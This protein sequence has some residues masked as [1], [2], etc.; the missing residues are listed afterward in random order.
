MQDRSAFSIHA[1]SRSFIASTS[2]HEGGRRSLAIEVGRGLIQIVID[3]SNVADIDL[4]SIITGRAEIEINHAGLIILAEHD[5]VRENVRAFPLAVAF[6]R[7]E[8]Q[9]MFTLSNASHGPLGFE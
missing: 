1:K 9:A 8:E 3:G 5:F 4:P 6:T 2:R 7:E